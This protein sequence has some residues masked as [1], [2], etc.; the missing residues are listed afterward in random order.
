M[1]K[2]PVECPL[3]L[4]C[5]FLGRVLWMSDRTRISLA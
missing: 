4:E 2:G 5:N 1:R 3:L